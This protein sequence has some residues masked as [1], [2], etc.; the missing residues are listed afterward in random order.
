MRP[1][2]H[3]T[4]FLR[5]RATEF[6]EAITAHQY[7]K[8]PE[9]EQRHGESG[10]AKCVKDAAYHL[11]YLADAVTTGCPELFED[12]VSWAA[13][14]L[15]VYGIPLS[16]LSTHLACMQAVLQERL[17]SALLPL[18]D[19]CIH[20][21]MLVLSNQPH[22]AQSYLDLQTVRKPLANQYLGALLATDRQRAQLLIRQALDSGLRIEDLYLQVFQ[23]C[24]LEV[25]RL[26]QLRQASVGQEHY[27]T[28]VT[29][30]I[31]GHLYQSMFHTPRLGHTAVIACVG[32]ELHEMGARMVADF[33]ELA[34]WNT[35]FLGANTPTSS[36]VQ[37][38]NREHADLVC[39]STTLTMHL[40]LVV[41]AIHALRTDSN[42]RKV[43]IVVGGYPFQIASDLW[44]RLG[45]DGFA[46]D[47]AA[48]VELAARL[49]A[50]NR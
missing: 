15:Q 11:L 41:E 30:S 6:A 3:D 20:R 19:A 2:L 26:W 21:G 14:L 27:C 46:P 22:L 28:A 31:M 32:N 23:P 33:L 38:A 1:E 25:G 40:H 18:V 50:N 5:V 16:D 12:Y 9:L 37:M 13:I 39:L 24:Q 47:A 4:A 49:V 7:Q 34:G 43:P 10:R 42:G 8:W 29:Q 36:I 17:P 35:I 45:A 48:A 44:R